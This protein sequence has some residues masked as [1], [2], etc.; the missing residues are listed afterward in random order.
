MAVEPKYRRI[1]DA[2]AERIRA[3]DFGAD[4]ALPP[5]RV[6]SDEYNVTLMTLR[7]ALKALQDDGLIEQRAG[8][9]TFV[10]PPEVTHDQANLRS[11]ADELNTQGVPLRTEVLDVQTGKLPREVA[12][13]LGVPAEAAALRLERLRS[14]RGIPLL[15]Q[16]SWVPQP[17][18]QAIAEVDFRVTPLYGAIGEATGTHPERAEEA[19]TAEA[20]SA[21]L[22]ALNSTAEGRPALVMRRTTFDG[23]GRAYV[24]DTATILDERL[25]IVTDRRTS[26]VTH[27]WRFG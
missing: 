4:G 14:V 22:A 20:L 24:V 3:G 25:R 17:W 23:T 13:E 19:L 26:E 15:H 8:R 11:L 10:V 1:A 2:L 9:G 12:I 27:T 7:Q 5:Q 21:G 18:A 6:L 16:V